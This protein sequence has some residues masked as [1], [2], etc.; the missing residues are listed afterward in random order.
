MSSTPASIPTSTSTPSVG[1][2]IVGADVCVTVVRFHGN[3][4]ALV[5]IA[6]LGPTATLWQARIFRLGSKRIYSKCCSQIPTF[7]TMATVRRV[8]KD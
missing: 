7:G 8:S 6:L 3:G 4:N 5:I 2:F 1:D